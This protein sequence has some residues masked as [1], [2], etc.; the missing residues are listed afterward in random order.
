MTIADEARKEPGTRGVCGSRLGE[1]ERRRVAAFGGGAG[2]AFSRRGARGGGGGGAR[3]ARDGRRYG[4][5]GNTATAAEGEGSAPS[6]SKKEKE[7][8]KKRRAKSREQNAARRE[9]PPASEPAPV[10]VRR[11]LAVGETQPPI[12]P[13]REP[14]GGKPPRCSPRRDRTRPPSA[15]KRCV[16]DAAARACFFFF[17]FLDSSPPAA[18]RRDR[19]L[20][21]STTDH[22][23][24]TQDRRSPQRDGRR[25]LT[26]RRGAPPRSWHRLTPG[27]SEPAGVPSR[28][29]RLD[30]LVAFLKRPR[31]VLDFAGRRLRPPRRRGGWPPTR[32]PV[33]GEPREEEEQEA[34]AFRYESGVGCMERNTNA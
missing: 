12:A 4:Q 11:Q 13:G 16:V 6:L 34:D 21:D 20:D 8:L 15:T 17:F 25:A 28:G 29:G 33:E 32:E 30:R 24:C 18:A 3:R 14:K 2:G 10:R 26:Q 7:K 19:R 23:P 22:R 27:R 5:T 1:K 9:A 31:E